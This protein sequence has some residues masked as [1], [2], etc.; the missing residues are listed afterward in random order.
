MPHGIGMYCPILYL[1]YSS[2]TRS[3]QSIVSRQDK[4]AKTLSQINYVTDKEGKQTE[5]PPLNY[6]L[7]LMPE[8]SNH[9]E[10]EQFSITAR[11][12]VYNKSCT[13]LFCYFQKKKKIMPHWDWPALSRSILSLFI[14]HKKYPINCLKT[15]QTSYDVVSN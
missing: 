8:N 10:R 15:R 13:G 1:V 12:T 14:K 2:N 6:H 3:T 9:K 5:H 7:F 11:A 4:Q